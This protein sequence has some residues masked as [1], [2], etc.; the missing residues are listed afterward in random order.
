MSVKFHLFQELTNLFTA[1]IVLDN[2]NQM[3]REVIDIPEMTEV[4]DIPEMT[5]VQDIPEMTEVQEMI[6]EQNLQL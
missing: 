5:E 3:I 4:Q 2:T 6:A 1:V